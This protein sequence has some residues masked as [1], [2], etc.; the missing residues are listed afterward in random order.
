MLSLIFF[1]KQPHKCCTWKEEGD[2]G[3]EGGGSW[4][5]GKGGVLIARS[6][7]LF[8]SSSTN[9]QWLDADDLLLS[10]QSRGNNLKK[11][12]PTQPHQQQGQRQEEGR[13]GVS[14]AV[15]RRR[16]RKMAGLQDANG[17]LSPIKSAQRRKRC[18]LACTGLNCRHIAGA[19]TR[20]VDLETATAKR[21][22]RLL[23]SISLVT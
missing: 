15:G 21:E 9:T 4:E 22:R 3:R 5:R 1:F 16:N 12:H 10:Q 18:Q 8:S 6:L 13:A 2:G 20:R 17:V 11:H 23:G 7:L 19:K 14:G